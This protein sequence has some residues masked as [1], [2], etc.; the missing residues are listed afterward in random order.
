MEWGFLERACASRGREILLGL[1]FLCSTDILALLK[2]AFILF[3]ARVRVHT[4]ACRQMGAAQCE[5]C[6]EAKWVF[7]SPLPEPPGEEELCWGFSA[8]NLKIQVAWVKQGC[9]VESL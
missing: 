5:S 2:S 7:C 6:A 4:S 1:L 8:T 9:H 3:L